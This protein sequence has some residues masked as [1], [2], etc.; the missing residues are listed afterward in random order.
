M[1][2]KY[3]KMVGWC[4]WYLVSLANGWKPFW[5]KVQPWCNSG[6]LFGQILI[7]G[8]SLLKIFLRQTLPTVQQWKLF[9][10]NSSLLQEPAFSEHVWNTLPTVQQWKL[11]HTN[12][13]KGASFLK[14]FLKHTLTMVQR[15]HTNSI[16]GASFLKIVLRQR[17]STHGATVKEQ[18]R[19]EHYSHLLKHS[20]VL[21]GNWNFVQS[22]FTPSKTFISLS[23]KLKLCSIIILHK[24]RD[25][26]REP[27]P[28]WPKGREIGN[29]ANWP[30]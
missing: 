26:L 1:V 8:A 15:F 6:N 20:S 19:W 21:Q 24:N 3:G 4:Q 13:T 29:E 22:I 27:E 2:W 16:K 11:F 18:E 7:K 10:T 25:N 5:D 9:H 30:S 28:L 17:N 14:T 12:S 23:R